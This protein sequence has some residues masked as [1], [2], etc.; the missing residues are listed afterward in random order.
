V[1]KPKK[2][3]VAGSASLRGKCGAD[4]KHSGGKCGNPA[5]FGTTHLG[6]GRCKFH[7]GTTRTHVKS[8]LKEEAVLMGCPKDMN[9]V[10]AMIWC[11]RITAG[12]VEWLTER[13]S[14]VEEKNWIEDTVIGKQV[15]LWVRER[16]EAQQRL[17][18]FSREAIALGLAE[19]AVKMAEMYGETLA[20]LLNGVLTDLQL[21]K[22]QR[23][24]APTVIRKHLS[25]MEARRS[26]VK[27][28]PSLVEAA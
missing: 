6:I 26:A 1:S 7:G 8:A 23:A 20:K 24:L 28:I 22:K 2:V 25:L 4:K 27:E 3:G 17:F 10:D 12:E 9:P 16:K 13:I 15:H 5:G 19:R 11:I 14:T 18:K 21:S